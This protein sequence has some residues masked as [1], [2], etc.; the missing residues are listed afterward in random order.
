[1]KKI[2]QYATTLLLLMVVGISCEEG[3]DNWRIITDVQPGL[4]ISG[5]ATIYSADATSSLL[6]KPAFDGKA[7]DVEMLGIYTWLKKDGAFTIL[8][9]DADGKQVRYGKGETVAD[10]TGTSAMVAEAAGFSVDEDGLYYVAYNKKDKQLSIIPVKFGII[11]DATPGKWSDETPM[12]GVSYDAAQAV[13]EFSLKDVVLDKKEMKFRYLA[14]WGVE[15][16]YDG[17]LVKIHTN[18]GAVSAGNLSEAF[19]ECEGGGAN[20]AISKAGVYDITLKLDLRRGVFSAKGVCT[21]EDTSSATLPEKMFIIGSPWSWDWANAPEMNLVHSHDGLF[22]GIYYLNAGAEVKFNNELSWSAG[23][24]FGA[25]T[26]DPKGFGEY[27]AGGSNLKVENEGYYQILV[28]CVL[29]ADKKSVERSIVLSEPVPYLIGNTIGSWDIKDE[30]KFTLDAATK[31]YVSPALTASDNLRICVKL[32]GCDWWQSEF[33][34]FDGKI[35]FRGKGN[36]QEAV[37]AQAGQVVR[38][39]FQDNTGTIK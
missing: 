4:Y 30:N 18:M 3:N 16:P 38:L 6:K 27:A 32:D 5:D 24:N 11:G 34:V 23:D 31:E 35:V 13:V 1:M 14:T 8:E 10:G 33:N 9:V 28:K 12:T 39:N 29:S 21:A 36:D 2:I 20:F 7:D 26:A 19:S 22:W 17:G 25:E 15:L 37:P